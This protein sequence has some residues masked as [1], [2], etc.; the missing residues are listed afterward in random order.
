MGEL[1]EREFKK[2][3]EEK[4]RHKELMSKLT[5][6]IKVVMDKEFSAKESSI[7]L[8]TLENTLKTLQL[9]DYSDIPK[10]IKAMGEALIKS[11]N[12]IQKKDS[13]WEHEI[14][15]DS[16]GLTKTIISTPLT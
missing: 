7:D 13:T 10:S 5:E 14:I 16:Q 15:R 2:L 4:T 8:R 1:T 11:I 6:L 9:P 12:K 3:L